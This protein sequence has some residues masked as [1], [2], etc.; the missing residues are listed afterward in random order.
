MTN[1]KALG[2]TAVLLGMVMVWNGCSAVQVRDRTYLQAIEVKNADQTEVQLHDFETPGILSETAGDNLDAALQ[3]ASVFI[4]KELFLGHLELIAYASP[5]FTE[6][7]SQCMEEYRLSPACKVLG[8]T[9]GQTLEET[10]TQH[11]MEQLRRAE[12]SGLFPETDLF[13]VQRELEGTGGTALMPVLTR[14]GD[15]AA[16]VVTAKQFCGVV[17]EKAAAGLCWLRGDNYPKQL[18]LSEKENFD[19][20]YGT[21]RLSAYAED[22]H[23]AVTAVVHLQG[24]GDFDQAAALIKSQCQ[25]AITETV[26]EC[27]ADVFDIEACLRSQCYAYLEKTT[28]DEVL[29]NITFEIQVVDRL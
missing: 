22:D 7:L 8:L 25:A 13:S 20:S 29:K 9:K 5:A 28:W 19:I 21:I 15:F 3:K 12:D 24:K 17:S 18:A 11:L 23:V 6:R 1:R 10:D 4:G 14:D 2:M 27:H 16:A 26:K